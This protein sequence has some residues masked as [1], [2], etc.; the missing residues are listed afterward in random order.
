MTRIVHVYIKIDTSTET[1]LMT[2][3]DL[4]SKL[5]ERGEN[6]AIRKAVRDGVKQGKRAIKKGVTSADAIPAGKYMVLEGNV[7][8]EYHGKITDTRVCSLI[9]IERDGKWTS[10]M[11]DDEV[12]RFTELTS[13]DDNCFIAYD[14]FGTS[15]ILL[16]ANPIPN[17]NP[18]IISSPAAGITV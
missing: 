2:V 5:V 9:A 14:R 13:T 6:S 17:S 10:C 4:V 18:C 7:H 16:D 1:Y 15:T 12:D 8:N 11:K 3:K